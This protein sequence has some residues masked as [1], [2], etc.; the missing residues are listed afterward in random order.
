MPY[1]AHFGLNQRPFALTPNSKLYFPSDNHQ[2]VL[3]PLSYAIDRGS[4][5]C[6]S[7]AVTALSSSTA[8]RWRF[9]ERSNPRGF[10]EEA[11]R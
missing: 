8:R 1:L 3:T 5:F 10:W 2:Q 11:T 7:A 4:S 6:T 9:L